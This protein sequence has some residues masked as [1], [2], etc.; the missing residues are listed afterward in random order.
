MDKRPQQAQAETGWRAP[1][2]PV[3]RLQPAPALRGSAAREADL[4][5]WTWPF[6]ATWPFAPLG[7]GARRG[8]GGGYRDL[9]FFFN[10]NLG[11]RWGFPAFSSL[12][13]SPFTQ[14]PALS[15]E[16]HPG[17]ESHPMAPHSFTSPGRATVNSG[18]ECWVQVAAPSPTVWPLAKPCPLCASVT[19]SN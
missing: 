12:S 15:R 3:D 19:L 10:L 9:Y 13:L 5:T 4:W 14:N 7:G 6:A 11:V 1:W 17:R 8:A 18:Q 16:K 2:R